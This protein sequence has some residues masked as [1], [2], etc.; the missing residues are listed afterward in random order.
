MFGKS[1]QLTDIIDGQSN[2]IAVG[3]TTSDLGWALP[4]TGD[5][6]KGPNHGAAFG[7]SHTA[8]ANFLFCDGSV[9]F[10]EDAV[11]SAVF[12]AMFTTAGR[13]SATR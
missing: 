3:E 11:D 2:T 4:G 10:I 5:G 8:G 13:E 7:S 1:I 6:S 9:D 12:S